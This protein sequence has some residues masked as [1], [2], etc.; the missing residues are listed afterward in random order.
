MP[1]EKNSTLLNKEGPD[2]RSGVLLEIIGGLAKRR[3]VPNP[4]HIETIGVYSLFRPDA[5][6]ASMVMRKNTRG[7]Q[8]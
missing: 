4:C 5:A 2:D 7:R 8:E 6:I 1:N 3:A